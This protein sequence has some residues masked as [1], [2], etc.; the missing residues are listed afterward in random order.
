[1]GHPRDLGVK[2]MTMNYKKTKTKH[3]RCTAIMSNV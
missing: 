3:S 2:L 1:M